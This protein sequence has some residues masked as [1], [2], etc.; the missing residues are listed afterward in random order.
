MLSDVLD[1]IGLFGSVMEGV[2]LT[3]LEEVIALDDSN[4]VPVIPEL[5]LDEPIGGQVKVF[6]GWVLIWVVVGPP[7]P[8]VC[9]PIAEVVSVRESWPV[10]E[11]VSLVKVSRVV[12]AKLLEPPDSDGR[13]TV[14]DPV[15]AAVPVLESW[16]VWERVSVFDVPRV[17]VGRSLKPPEPVERVMEMT[18]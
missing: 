14:C 1:M 3:V 2:R 12:V 5:V 11:N 15:G 8:E 7:S 4:V 6:R 18:G 17:E 9:V 16:P 10:C 13:V